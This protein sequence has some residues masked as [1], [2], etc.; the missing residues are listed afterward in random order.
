MN[1]PD[2]LVGTPRGETSRLTLWRKRFGLFLTVVVVVFLLAL[3]KA[4]IH[5][6]EWEFLNLN[7]LFTSVI[8]GAVFIIGFLLSS[9]LSDYKEAERI[10][11]EIRI[12]LEA[13]YDDCLGFARR[14]KTIAI[15]PL[16]QLLLHIV[17]CIP[18]KLGQADAQNLRT[19]I[20]HIDELTAYFWD[21][22]EAGMPPNFVVRLR[23]EQSMLRRC[24]FRM[25]HMQ[26]IQFI[27]SVHVLV[28]SLVVA[29]ISLLLFLKTE[30]SPESALIFGAISYMFIYV[31]YLVATL[32]QPFRK[33]RQTLD[34]VSLFLLREFEEKLIR[35]GTDCCP[36]TPR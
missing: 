1:K 30:G 5:S 2:C 27:P 17:S 13:I 24:I 34:D 25:Y 31:P 23:S 3:A 11:A 7:A 9:I 26:R 10:P 19:V 16:R 21:L 18:A 28:Q 15:E 4:A 36:V 6:V 12:A 29:V 33:G 22:E 35:C 14:Q 8:A 32:E 20:A